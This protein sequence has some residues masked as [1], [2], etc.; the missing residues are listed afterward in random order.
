MPSWKDR[1]EAATSAP[2]KVAMGDADF[3][4][5]KILR[6]LGW[7]EA[8]LPLLCSFLSCEYDAGEPRIDA[9]RRVLDFVSGG[10]FGAMSPAR[11]FILDVRN[12]ASGRKCW[13][14]DTDLA[15]MCEVAKSVPGALIVC[16][17]VKS[18]DGR[19]DGLAFVFARDAGEVPEWLLRPV[20]TYMARV[21]GCMVWRR[22]TIELIRDMAECLKW[23]IPAQP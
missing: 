16:S 17:R 6:G 14:T 23:N 7:N 18:N 13:K 2:N 4:A 5:R 11:R 9:V 19:D 15:L 3:T 12:C 10:A 22:E 8:K 20:S 1:L 21:N